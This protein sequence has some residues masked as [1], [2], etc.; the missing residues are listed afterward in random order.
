MSVQ[1]SKEID[2]ILQPHI[3]SLQKLLGSPDLS[4]CGIETYPI[5]DYILW[6]KKNIDDVGAYSIPFCD[7]ILSHEYT[8]IACFDSLRKSQMLLVKLKNSSVVCHW[9]IWLL[10]WSL[11]ERLVISKKYPSLEQ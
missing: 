11:I 7:N 2:D 1:I 8:K 6:L 3:A 10:S 9:Y 5:I 4:E